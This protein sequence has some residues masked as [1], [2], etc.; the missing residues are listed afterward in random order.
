MRYVVHVANVAWPALGLCF[1]M[2]QDHKRG[3]YPIRC[4]M[5]PRWHGVFVNPR[6]ERWPV[7]ACDEHAVGLDQLRPV[8]R[9]A[10]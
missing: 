9:S 10:S 6:G 8:H 2:V 5:P 1:R 4:P 3:G 7:D